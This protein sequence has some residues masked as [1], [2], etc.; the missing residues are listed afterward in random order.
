[1]TDVAV[2]VPT[3]AD[4]A[5]LGRLLPRLAQLRPAPA[6]VIVV[7]GAASE[8]T[9][10]LCAASGAL[11]I[12]TRPGRGAQLA[13]GAA[14]ARADV[15]WFVHADAEPQPEAVAAI[16]ECIAAGALGGHFRFRFTGPATPAKRLLER[17]I[18]WR[19]RLGMVYGDQGL[20]VTR[21]A[22][23]AT[24]GFTPD[25]LFEEVALVRALRRT[26]RFVALPI[27]LGV[28]PR[29]WER[30]GWLRRTLLNR[31]LATGYA[32]GVPPARLAAWYGTARAT[33]VVTVRDAA[34]AP[35]PEEPRAGRG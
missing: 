5:A 23:A 20:F 30:D 25:P 15:L 27:P 10:R 28:S 31:A 33:A 13:A 3:L 32:L 21:E 19:C 26:G 24:P 4:D 34:A 17:C 6:A 8:A 9:A 2:I 16:R 22:Y 35:L 12:G 14:R 1:M 7:D 18:A 29:R 11:W